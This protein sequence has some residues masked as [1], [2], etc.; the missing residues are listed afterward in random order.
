MKRL[1][2]KIFD[3]QIKDL[4]TASY[5]TAFKHSVAKLADLS[6]LLD[7]SGDAASAD[8]VDNV[9]KQAASLW[10]FLVGGIGGAATAKDEA[11]E[12]FGKSVL[13]ALKSGDW[14]KLFDKQTLVNVITKALTG[15]VIALIAGEL[16][17]ALGDKIPGFGLIKNTTFVRTAVIGAI[18]YAVTNSDFVT[19]L[20][21]GLI[22]EVKKALGMEKAVS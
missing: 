6:D 1:A 4:L 11:G 17:D 12:S 9:L 15:S 20:V 22:V 18:T 3:D 10:D 13:D 8:C 7:K 14:G 16:L 5:T 21:D 19:K 2:Q